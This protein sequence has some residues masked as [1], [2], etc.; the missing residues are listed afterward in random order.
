MTL[1]YK[2]LGSEIFKSLV[3]QDKHFVD[4]CHDLPTAIFVKVPR[5]N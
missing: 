3:K 5:G 4:L 2:T 1:G